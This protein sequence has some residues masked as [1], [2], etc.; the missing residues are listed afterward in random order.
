M[1]K[2]GSFYTRENGLENGRIEPLGA[3]PGYID[4]PLRALGRR[5]H[6]FSFRILRI[7]GTE[8]WKQE[9]D[10]EVGTESIARTGNNLGGSL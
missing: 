9:D 10:L 7:L 6:I 8:S 4:F 1:K 2:H 5:L 3:C